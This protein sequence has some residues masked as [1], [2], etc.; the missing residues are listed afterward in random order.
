[1]LHF[2]LFSYAHSGIR[3][4]WS[5][6]KS[7]DGCIHYQILYFN[8]FFFQFITRIRS[9]IIYF[10]EIQFSRFLLLGS[11]KYT[12]SIVGTSYLILTKTDLYH[13]QDFAMLHFKSKFQHKVL[14]P[15]KVPIWIEIICEYWLATLHEQV[16]D[17]CTRKNWTDKGFEPEKNNMLDVCLWQ[18]YT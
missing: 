15:I 1:M 6:S 12:Q 11:Q 14:F 7:K 10:I 16:L 2:V 9:S 18:R 17:I 13:P 8:I 4:N 3:R 5:E